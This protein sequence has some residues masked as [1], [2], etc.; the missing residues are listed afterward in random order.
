MLRSPPGDRV[1]VHITEPIRRHRLQPAAG[2]VR[3]LPQ[4]LRQPL[5]SNNR[6]GS[7]AP[8]T[9]SRKTFA[10]QRP[11]GRRQHRRRR[12]ELRHGTLR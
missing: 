10:A 7:E 3:H 5:R 12:V 8:P 2:R 11:T 1:Q 9:Q 6:A 4:P